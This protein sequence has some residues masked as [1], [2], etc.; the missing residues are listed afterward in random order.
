VRTLALVFTLVATSLPTFCGADEKDAKPITVEAA[1]KKVNEKCTVEMKV[2]SVGK[3][4]TAY[5]L[6]S[7]SNF[8]DEGN[9]TV[10]IKKTGVESFKVAKIEDIPAHFKDKTILVSGIVTLYQEDP[11][12]VVEKAEQVRI[13]EKK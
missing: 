13:V 3:G 7:K 1:A 10:F 8:R 12:I 2:E 5:F 11:Q 6:N 9:F 4:G